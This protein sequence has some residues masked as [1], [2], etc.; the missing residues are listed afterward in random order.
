MNKNMPP[1]PT[2][3]PAAQ[4]TISITKFRPLG[5]VFPI[6]AR[7]MPTPGTTPD[8]P[9]VTNGANITLQPPEGSPVQLI[10]ELSEPQYVLL[11]AA[12]GTNTAVPSVGQATF[13]D[14]DIRHLCNPAGVPTGSRMTITD[15]AHFKGELPQVFNYV[16]L[17][18]DA[19]SGEIGIID[20]RIVNRPGGPPP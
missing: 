2:P 13:P 19:L 17:V 7:F 18:Q 8:F 20:P 4:F 9:V 5:G 15:N 16:I 10:F 6:S 3:L 14:I 11:G 1:T 12:F